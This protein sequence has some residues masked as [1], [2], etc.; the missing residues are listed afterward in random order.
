MQ[1]FNYHA[2]TE[3]VFG[4]GA[5]GGNAALI[6]K[7]GGTRVLIVYG[8]QSAVKS[9]LI[10]KVK[11]L[12]ET[13]QITALEFGGVMTNPTLEKAREGVKTAITFKADFILAVG[14]GSAIDT[15]K[16][17]A[18][19]T[20][21]PAVDIWKF[22]KREEALSVSLPVGCILTI[23]AA[24]SETSASAVLTN[25]E[26]GEKRGLGSELNRPRFAVM[27]PELTF[28]VPPYHMACGIADIFMHTADRFFSSCKEPNETTDGIAIVIMRTVIKNAPII[29]KNPRDYNAA[30]EI[31]WCGSLSHNGLTGLGRPMDFSVHQLSHELSARFDAAHGAS[32]TAVWGSWAKYCLSADI[33]RFAC[34]AKRVWDIDEKDDATTAIV[35][36]EKT[37]SFF[38]ALNL[39]VSIPDLIG[40]RLDAKILNGLAYACSFKDTRLIGSMKPLGFKEI[41]E[42]Y[43]AANAY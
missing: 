22:W 37:A 30:S 38:R 12:L 33:P 27:D 14:G 19:G 40:Y 5:I 2:P 18:H 15:A 26:T 32:L 34:F 13:L 23:S 36:I 9:G 35:G 7:Y 42:V 28:S 1:N 41:E 10:T 8:N 20:A 4:R 39:P 43:Q 17:I 31:M 24:G 29:M 11:G 3:I 6:K 16:A 25:T 21:N